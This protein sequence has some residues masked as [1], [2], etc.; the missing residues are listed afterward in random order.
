MAAVELLM[1]V[2]VVLADDNQA[3]LRAMT[4]LLEL[5]PLV[6]V[7]GTA[8]STSSAVALVQ[9]LKPD[10]VLVDLAMPEIPNG[11]TGIREIKAL[12]GLSLVFALTLHD[13]L[14]C[15]DAVAAAGAD[16]FVA[17]SNC[18]AVLPSLL[19]ETAVRLGNLASSNP[20]A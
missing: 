1:P 15:R 6:R 2:R 4:E 5:D 11:L 12:P 3:F 13:D 14:E 10:V 8:S 17:K 9:R 18:Y 7:V 19:R 16:G 20:L